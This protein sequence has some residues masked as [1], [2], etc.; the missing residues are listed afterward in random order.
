MIPVDY[1]ILAQAA[2][3]FDNISP[4]DCKEF[5]VLDPKCG[6]ALSML[7][8]SHPMVSSVMIN[9]GRK[10]RVQRFGRLE[11]FLAAEIE[12]ASLKYS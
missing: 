12:S 5:G 9:L 6:S 11:S 2:A 3:R 1:K 4:C 10:S 7:R 8:H